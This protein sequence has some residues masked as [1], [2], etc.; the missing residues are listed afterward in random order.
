[1]GATAD[2]F[3][4]LKAILESEFELGTDVDAIERFED[5]P[6][7]AVEAHVADLSGPT[8]SSILFGMATENPSQRTA[9]G[10]ASMKSLLL[11]FVI[12]RRLSPHQMTA[13]EED[14]KASDDLMDRLEDLFDAHRSPQTFS[15]LLKNTAVTNIN[16][17]SRAPVPAVGELDW[18]AREINFDAEI[19]R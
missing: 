16:L 14:L 10:G 15:Q 4:E 11:S 9:S 2:T 5:E 17:S 6:A 13:L 1:M 12:V 19:S 18:H 8:G 3:A 7:L